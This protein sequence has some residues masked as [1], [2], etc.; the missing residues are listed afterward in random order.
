VPEVDFF[1]V[2]KSTFRLM[3]ASVPLAGGQT[4]AAESNE[5]VFD[6]RRKTRRGY[7]VEAS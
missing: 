7:R 4:G 3:Y 2:Q 1:L 6:F 5:Q